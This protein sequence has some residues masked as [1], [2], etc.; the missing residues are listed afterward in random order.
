MKN[1][2]L[3][4]IICGLMLYSCGKSAAVDSGSSEASDI[5]QP[6]AQPEASKRIKTVV[7][8]MAV[9]PETRQAILDK[10][11]A[12]EIASIHSHTSEYAF[13]TH[14]LR[15][16][17][18][19]AHPTKD[20]F[21]TLLNVLNVNQDDPNDRQ[22]VDAFIRS[23]TNTPPKDWSPICEAVRCHHFYAANKL[24]EAGANIDE[25][26]PDCLLQMIQ[27]ENN[28][29]KPLD[30]KK[31]LEPLVQLGVSA[32]RIVQAI[33]SLDADR[34][35][36]F[37]DEYDFDNGIPKE[38]LDG[39]LK[40]G[41]SKLEEQRAQYHDDILK[42][43]DDALEN[44]YRP[45]DKT[46]TGCG[47][48]EN[49]MEMTLERI[50]KLGY[51]VHLDGDSADVEQDSDNNDAG[52]SHSDQ[53]THY[54]PSLFGHMEFEH[55]WDFG[56]MYDVEIEE[57]ETLIKQGANVNER[58]SRGRTPIFEVHEEETMDI[59]VKHGA[60]LNAQ[61]K[62]GLT[63]AMAAEIDPAY[64]VAFYKVNHLIEL[65]A[66][67]NITDKQGQNVL[68][69]RLQ[70]G[71]YEPADSQAVLSDE[72]WRMRYVE[73]E[74]KLMETII[75]KGVK[76]NSVDKLGRTALFYYKHPEGAAFYKTHGGDINATD[77]TGK[78]ALMVTDEPKVAIAL[79]A[80]GADVHIRDKAGQ[81][82]LDVHKD[83][84]EI[85]HAIQYP[86]HQIDH[87]SE[88]D[89]RGLVNNGYDI[90]AMNEDGMTPAMAALERLDIV[91]FKSLIS[92]GANLNVKDANGKPLLFYLLH[93][94]ADTRIRPYYDE[95]KEFD[96]GSADIS[97]LN[98]VIARGIDVN[99]KDTDGKTA[100]MQ[101]GLNDEIVQTL[102]RAGAAVQTADNKG[103]TA[104]YYAGTCFDYENSQNLVNSYQSGEE[105]R[106]VESLLKAGN[107]DVNHRDADGL[108][109]LSMRTD[110]GA[111]EALVNAGFDI[112]AK[113]ANGRTPVYN[114]LD[115]MY[116]A[117]LSASDNAFSIM[118]LQRLHADLNVRDN[119]GL[120]PIL[121]IL[122]ISPE[123]A[124]AYIKTESSYYDRSDLIRSRVA[125][126]SDKLAQYLI[127]A[128]A[129]INSADNAGRTPL[130]LANSIDLA[131][132]L[133]NA[134]ANPQAKDN[135]GKSVMDY[136][137]DHADILDVLIYPFHHLTM[138]CT[139]ECIQNLQNSY[140]IDA[141][142]VEGLTPLMTLYSN[143]EIVQKLL[144]A[145][146]DVNAKDTNGHT[147]RDY[148]QNDPALQWNVATRQK[149]LSMLDAGLKEPP[150]P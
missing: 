129:D 1:S 108:S 66:K 64:G 72:H 124:E 24:K 130:M 116:V 47:S 91:S 56:L 88:A 113:A 118:E 37:L 120:S 138:A 147:V 42:Q 30:I 35:A 14:I 81:T 33:D 51:L 40:N 135:A 90:D 52:N 4:S 57:I 65:G 140:N 41:I 79:L 109:P 44:G 94:M 146:A 17:N 82:A 149:L 3:L 136:H 21:F 32:D 99:V 70:K 19:G 76:I 92:A 132:Y 55:W 59:L 123:K 25:I 112:N 101:C 7:T 16:I 8:P 60:N 38:V 97:V 22:M 148:I 74:L 84:K 6:I 27:Y 125:A 100:L 45:C 12:R 105:Q 29:I 78:T 20:D 117:C 71:N 53:N 115:K 13:R 131:Q 128:G 26:T 86:L 31:N 68:F 2:I 142:D 143:S 85:M 77:K 43:L 10:R 11:L 34:L 46:G 134:G 141:P 15:L 104:L 110:L 137:K 83:H 61:D 39:I 119:Q 145:G 95:L 49:Y 36:N 126:C 102:L 96:N 122:N 80:A 139:Q 23:V 62:D 87:C 98:D 114:V 93:N 67:V 150:A 28:N 107:P 75:A 50:Q 63:P 54:R 121:Y 133:V 48:G 103:R 5:T 73:D 89:V 106:V 9:A 69:K 127:V 144:D 58:D 18:S 111:F